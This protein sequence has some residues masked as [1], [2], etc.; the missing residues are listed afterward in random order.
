MGTGSVAIPTLSLLLKI[1]LTAWLLAIAYLDM[2]TATISN[3]LTLPVMALSGGWR[4]LAGSWYLLKAMVAGLG[5]SS[6]TSW[7]RTANDARAWSALVFMCVA[8][9]CVFVLWEL[10]IL[11]GGDTKTLMGILA[12]FPSGDF[13]AFLAAAVLV[14]SLPLLT[15]RLRG[16]RWPDVA[17]ALHKRLE[18][19]SLFP[20]QRELQ[21][22]GRPYAW[23][24]CLP[25]VI[26]VWL[27]W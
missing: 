26:Y 27:L 18:R 4:V 14:L 2:R 12:L 24:F 7:Q 1:V 23:T 19:G 21:E 16:R 3:R 8:W 10:H 13:V 5:L 6:A 11:G 9:A 20:T 15:L 17:N 22:Q 25:A